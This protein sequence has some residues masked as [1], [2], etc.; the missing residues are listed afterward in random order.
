MSIRSD[1][2]VIGAGIAGASVSAFL[3]PHCAVTL[4]EREVAPGHHSTGRSAA[5][6]SVAI[7]TPAMRRLAQA[8]RA[9]F[10][11]PPT[12]FA[13]HPLVQPRGAMTVAWGTSD[14]ALRRDIETLSA[15]DARHRRLDAADTLAVCPYLKADGLLGAVLEEDAKD[16]DVDLLLQGY[17]RTARAH[18]LVDRYSAGVEAISRQADGWHVRTANEAFIAPVIVNAAGAWTDTIAG[19]AGI[20]PLGLR[21]YRRTAF[22]FAAP[23]DVDSS[24]WPLI[25]SSVGNWYFKP[26]AGRL[27]GSLADAHEVPPHDVLPEDIDVA[28]GL[29]NL[30]ADTRLAIDRPLSAW[31][32]LRTFAS[33]DDP[34]AGFDA[35]AQGFFWLGGQGGSGVLSSPGLGETAATLVLGRPLP[36]A[37]RDLGLDPAW[38]SPDRLRASAAHR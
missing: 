20:A 29:E 2:I 23:T 15:T 26:D 34:V 19:L 16:I 5:I 9:F 4:L 38:L 36:A 18:G 25:W 30:M 32:G 37:L 28:Q 21:A 12:G 3:A 7:T 31:A 22:S 17:L 10:D 1:V 8:S 33:D 11:S 27:L 35:S 24:R 13:P 6:F 14:E